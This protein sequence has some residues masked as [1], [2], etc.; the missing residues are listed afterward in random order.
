MLQL[1]A[2]ESERSRVTMMMDSQKLPSKREILMTL[3]K[4]IVPGDFCPNPKQF[5]L[6]I[7]LHK[8]DEELIAWGIEELAQKMTQKPMDAD[9]Q[10]RF[11]SSVLNRKREEL[12]TQEIHR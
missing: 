11:V 10:V 1:R 8:G 9:Y 4:D 6:W 7:H 3:W 5:N 12:Q 2:V